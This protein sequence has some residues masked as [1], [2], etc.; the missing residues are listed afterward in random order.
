M[1]RSSVLAPPSSGAYT[2]ATFSSSVAKGSTAGGSFQKIDVCRSKRQL[3]C[4]VGYSTYNETPPDG[5]IFGRG[6]A[7]EDVIRAVEFEERQGLLDDLLVHL[8]GEVVLEGPAVDPPRAGARDDP[9]AGDGLLAA[10][11]GGTGDGDL[12]G[13]LGLG[14]DGGVGL[15]G[16][17]GQLRLVGV[18]DVLVHNV[19]H[20]LLFLAL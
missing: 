15:A 5:S 20:V 3:G 14:G 18:E 6:D 16:V 13:S 4:V 1:G 17:L 9:D 2:P 12:A 11:G 7:D 19:S 8:V 10:A